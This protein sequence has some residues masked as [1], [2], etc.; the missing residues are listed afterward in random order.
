MK[1]LEHVVT[2]VV[3]TA[4]ITIEENNEVKNDKKL[5]LIRLKLDK[6]GHYDWQLTTTNEGDLPIVQLLDN[7]GRILVETTGRTAQR[8][9]GN[10]REGLKTYETFPKKSRSDSFVGQEKRPAKK[11]RSSSGL[12]YMRIL[13]DPDNIYEK[14]RS[15]MSESR[16]DRQLQPY[17]RNFAEIKNFLSEKIRQKMEVEKEV[18]K[19]LTPKKSSSFS[20]SSGGKRKVYRKTKDSPRRSESREKV[21]LGLSHCSVKNCKFCET[22]NSYVREKNIKDNVEILPKKPP[23]DL[24]I[25][26]KKFNSATGKKSPDFGYDSILMSKKRNGSLE[27]QD[28]CYSMVRKSDTFKIIDGA[29]DERVEP[30]NEEITKD[31]FRRVYALLKQRRSESKALL[32]KRDEERNDKDVANF[33][34]GK[35]KL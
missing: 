1:K 5:P 28:L 24:R 2:A 27:L 21:D 35:P 34:E 13:E 19:K 17:N 32:K 4:P 33:E 22:M 31:Y 30:K 29:D 20:D 12:K 18:E 14:M 15:Y 10:F 23:S 3:R 26:K 16:P 25:G 6:P 11:R 8:A 9:R 7:D